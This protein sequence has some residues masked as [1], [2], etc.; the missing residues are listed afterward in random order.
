[1]VVAAH[2][3]DRREICTRI[4]V[5]KQPFSDNVGRTKAILARILGRGLVEAGK[6]VD[7]SFGLR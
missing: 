6:V 3:C 4:L 5:R 7:L 1:M 2:K